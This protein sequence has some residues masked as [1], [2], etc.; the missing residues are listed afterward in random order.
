LQTVIVATQ[1]LDAA[2]TAEKQHSQL[3]DRSKRK[4][5]RYA[6]TQPEAI[7]NTLHAHELAELDTQY[8]KHMQAV[9]QA[10]NPRHEHEAT[11]LSRRSMEKMQVLLAERDEKV[12]QARVEL[13][14][15]HRDWDRVCVKHT[16]FDLNINNARTVVQQ[17][18]VQFAEYYGKHF[19]E[20]FVL[21]DEDGSGCL[22]H[23]EIRRILVMLELD[24]DDTE[25]EAMISLVD[26]DGTGDIS[27]DEFVDL[28]VRRSMEEAN[29]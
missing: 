8:Q 15:R 14:A 17:A 18:K 24:V 7:A 2:V 11:K 9:A 29:K 28:M 26:E 3:V 12:N 25:F 23:A 6:G 22:D 21:L 16:Q 4:F 10:K 19:Q 5:D 27:C 1:Q 13:R 20:A